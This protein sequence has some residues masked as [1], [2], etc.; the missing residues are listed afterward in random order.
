MLHPLPR[1][2]SLLHGEP[3]LFPPV[4][5]NVSDAPWGF[6]TFDATSCQ[7]H[8]NLPGAPPARVVFPRT[9]DGQTRFSSGIEHAG[10]EATGIVFSVEIQREDG[11]TVATAEQLVSSGD[12]ARLSLVLPA[13][14]GRHRIIL[15]T[16]AEPDCLHVYNAW[17]R[18]INP[19][20]S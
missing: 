16:A 4:L 20:M 1:E 17:S 10:R 12:G 9:L 11:S 3:G 6:F 2:L 8:P 18:W 5:Q 15:Q 13:L 7:L 19:S 14:T